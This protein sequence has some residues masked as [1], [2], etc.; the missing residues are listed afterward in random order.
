MELETHQASGQEHGQRSA[1]LPIETCWRP[2]GQPI[3]SGYAPPDASSQQLAELEDLWL[4]G[5]RIEHWLQYGAG[6]AQ[7]PDEELVHQF[8][9][10]QP[11]RLVDGRPTEEDYPLNG[12]LGHRL[13]GF[14]SR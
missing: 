12:G 2:Q 11:P 1:L 3:P 4:P 9:N 7:R 13:V 14:R 5:I 10:G 6:N 8:A